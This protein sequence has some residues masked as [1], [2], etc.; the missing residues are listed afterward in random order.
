MKQIR[1]FYFSIFLLLSMFI[2]SCSENEKVDLPTSALIHYSVADKKVAFTALAHNADSYLWD[3]GDGETSSEPNPV[4]EYEA[5]GYYTVTLN[6][7][8]GTGTASDESNLAIALTPYVLLTGG[9]TAENGKT[10]R[11]SGNHSPFDYFANADANLSP[12]PGAPNPLPAGILGAG[13][14]LGE[15]YTDEF[16]FHFDGK[17]EHDV[18]D[19]KASFSGL[20]Y[21]F[22]TTGGAG[23]V[24]PSTDQDFG[25]CTGLYTPEAGATFTFAEGEDF[26]CSSVYSAD[27]TVTYEGVNTLDFSGTEFVGFMDFQRKVIVQEVTDESMRLVLFMAAGQDPSIIGINTNALVLTFEVVR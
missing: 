10:W 12:F 17:Y 22:V 3:F 19:D 25:L 7:T 14:G 4:H 1:L 9:P 26:T 13:L 5:G 20:V 11:L 27:G 18:K 8:G 16:T 21:Q 2:V 6:V 23:I 15:V 24:N